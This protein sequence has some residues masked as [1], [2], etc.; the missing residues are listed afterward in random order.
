MYTLNITNNYSYDI[1]VK[2]SSNDHI[3]NHNS[4]GQIGNLGNAIVNIAGMGQVNLLDLGEEKIPGYPAKETWGVL[5][6][7]TTSE[8]YYRYEGGGVINLTI[9]K[10]ATTTISTTTGTLIKIRLEELIVDTKI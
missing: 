1:I 3:I 4:K 8:A 10:F 6:R 7:A 5:V 2:T 9:D